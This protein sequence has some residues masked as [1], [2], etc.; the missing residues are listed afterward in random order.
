MA[1]SKASRSRAGHDQKKYRNDGASTI[2]LEGE[3][4]EPGSE[5]YAT[6]D[7]TFELQM[8]QGGHL[9]I[10]EDRSDAADRAAAEEAGESVSEKPRRSRS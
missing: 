2:V 6:L 3:E 7:P 9:V 4:L 8:L 5:F 1:K 10:L